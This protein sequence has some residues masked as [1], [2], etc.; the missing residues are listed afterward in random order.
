MATAEIPVDLRNPG[1]VFACLGFLE[2]ADVLCGGAEGGFE[3]EQRQDPRATFTVA[4]AGTDNPFGVVLEYLAKT[5][6][7]AMAPRDWIAPKRSERKSGKGEERADELIRVGYSP[8]PVPSEMALPI[9]IGG[10]NRPTVE[11][12]HWADGSSRDEFKL[13]AGN[14]SALTIASTLIRGRLTKKGKV[15]L[16]GV[17]QLWDER[18]DEL[19]DNPFDAVVP[20]GGSF[21]F[22]ARCAWEALD[23]GYSPN[24]QGHKVM[25]SPVVEVLAAWG[26]E[27]ARPHRL[28]V[29][30]YRYTAWRG[31]LPPTLA[32]AALTGE[33]GTWECRRFRME[34]GR[35][36]D[37]K[38]VRYAEE[39]VAR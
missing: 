5:D 6:V 16:I 14:R 29:R 19:L 17:R 37:N 27:N 26:L 34:L 3:W 18:R 38:V 25:G 32:R 36:G 7:H 10:G 2:G 4:T 30:L 11:L 12:G 28:D 22:D 33:I 31:L 1:Q 23:A 20:M 35:S 15:R 24:D 13:Y 8:T 9:R 39:E 21:N